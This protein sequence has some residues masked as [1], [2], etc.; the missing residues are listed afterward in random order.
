MCWG[1]L[2]LNILNTKKLVI[3]YEIKCNTRGW[4]DKSTG[5]F[6]ILEELLYAEILKDKKCP[7]SKFLVQNVHK[8]KNVMNCV[9]MQIYEPIVILMLVLGLFV[10][11]QDPWSQDPAFQKLLQDMFLFDW[12]DWNRTRCQLL[13]LFFMILLIPQRHNL[14]M[15]VDIYYISLFVLTQVILTEILLM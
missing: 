9:L 14:L 12:V 6:T 7:E 2:D 13:L 1:S 5:F 15:S 11:I 10:A 8:P 3:T 4:S